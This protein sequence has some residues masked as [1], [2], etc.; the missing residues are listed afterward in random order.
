M[1]GLLF[2]SLFPDV[3]GIE[4]DLADGAFNILLTV[5]TISLLLLMIAKLWFRPQRLA[6][7]VWLW[8]VVGIASASIFT[9]SVEAMVFD[10]VQFA[11]TI[12]LIL[13]SLAT[14]GFLYFLP[15]TFR[16]LRIL[17]RRRQ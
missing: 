8:G 4:Q 9:F 7:Y 17:L 16:A 1:T 13:H 5:I 14:L 2:L 11:A 10:E 6:I 15:R 3:I 12:F